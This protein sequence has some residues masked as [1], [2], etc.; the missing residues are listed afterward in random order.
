VSTTKD[1]LL[2]NG[3]FNDVGQYGTDWIPVGGVTFGSGH[4]GSAVIFNGTNTT[5]YRPTGTDLDIGYAPFCVDFWVKI[6]QLPQYP[7]TTTGWQNAI[8]SSPLPVPP[9]YFPP[10][11]G[12]IYDGD[13]NT[14]MPVA[15]G[16]GLSGIFDHTPPSN[17]KG[18]I[19]AS[20]RIYNYSNS[21]FSI[22][23]NGSTIP[24]NGGLPWLGWLETGGMGPGGSWTSDCDLVA[25]PS[26]GQISEVQRNCSYHYDDG[27]HNVY[28]FNYGT[29]FTNRLSLYLYIG[30]T[31]GRSDATLGWGLI[32]SG[33]SSYA[34]YDVT[35]GGNPPIVEGQWYHIVIS[36]NLNNSLRVYQDD[37]P[38]VNQNGSTDFS[39]GN[40]I[41]HITSNFNIGSYE[42]TSLFF[43]GAIDDFEI[44]VGD[45]E[46]IPGALADPTI[47]RSPSTLNV[48]CVEGENA[49]DRPFEIWNS[50]SAAGDGA[51]NLFY[52]GA[53]DQ[54]WLKIFGLDGL[55][56]TYTPVIGTDANKYRCI[57]SHTS[58]T[59]RQPVSIT[60]GIEGLASYTGGRTTVTWASHGLTSG[61]T[62]KVT[63][64]GITQPGWDALNGNTYTV[65]NYVDPNTFRITFDS[66]SLAPY[67]PGTDPGTCSSWP[68][69][70]RLT[71][72]SF[73]AN[74][75]QNSY[76]YA[77]LTGSDS[78]INNS[79]GTHIHY[80]FEFNS[81]GLSAGAY[82]A[83]LTI[84]G[85]Q[86]GN[87]PQTIIVNLNVSN[88]LPASDPV[89]SNSES[90]VLIDQIL[91]WTAGGEVDSYDVYFGI[92]YP[93]SLI[94]N[95]LDTSYDPGPLD[96]NTT[97]YWRIDEV[98]ISET[99]IGDDWTFDTRGLPPDPAT[100][101][102][103][104]DGEINIGRIHLLT[105]TAAPTA[106]SHDIYFGTS[107]PPPFVGNQLDTTYDPG[108]MSYGEY[109]W[110]VDEVD[111]C[112]STTAGDEWTFLGGL[113]DLLVESGSNVEIEE[114]YSG[115]GIAFS[116]DD[117][118]VLV[119][120]YFNLTIR[121]RQL[122][123]TP[124]TFVLGGVVRVNL[125]WYTIEPFTMTFGSDWETLYWEHIL[126]R[127]FTAHEADY[128]KVCLIPR[129]DIEI[130]GVAITEI[131]LI[132]IE[133]TNEVFTVSLDVANLEQ[134]RFSSKTK[135]DYIKVYKE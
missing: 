37:I 87:S 98:T 11:P 6:N 4:S 2:F 122:S 76:S 61:P 16:M 124:N 84:T 63:F 13:I 94:G 15:G 54:T 23:W 102:D 45:Y 32:R 64:S 83:T 88:M 128:V 60:K 25:G 92:S 72:S 135:P 118:A 24:L 58:K 47:A 75:W 35:W 39:A 50:N 110:R 8:S 30:P 113:E 21:V 33:T 28:V 3:N 103:P 22:I 66:S 131:K 19:T 115:K 93:P 27:T 12:P 108:D 129:D 53:K 120:T 9:P 91:S 62:Y 106:D 133:D 51:R 78:I 99:I 107:Y 134:T 79:D 41:A 52:T 117:S 114:Y 69:Y 127:K 68:T 26:G 31:Q 81:S 71:N 67:D 10:C 7:I 20:F 82:T 49:I 95:Q 116:F 5:V 96:Y 74:A 44:S 119:D 125:H 80:A 130:N 29:G 34:L 65:T 100:D 36:R 121:G 89:P 70:W 126:G 43:D 73:S 105:W 132:S 77:A 57:R 46:Y 48:S 1:L 38:L 40:S 55:T 18:F 97:Y 90:C 59:E 104:A 101:P 109:Y 112:D 17:D 123:G 14:Y 56:T 85:P 86:A 42:A 111:A